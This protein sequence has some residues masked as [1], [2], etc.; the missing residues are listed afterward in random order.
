MSIQSRQRGLTLVELMIAM[1]IGILML[2]GVSLLFTQNKQS[3]RQN[4]EI[5]RIQENARFA[6]EELSRDISM[7]GFFA[8]VVDSGAVDVDAGVLGKAIDCG[9]GAAWLY[10][11]TAGLIDGA[12]R[13]SDQVASGAA[14]AADFS[15]ITAGA[16]FIPDSDVIGIRRTAGVPS[17]WE[18]D[19]ATGACVDLALPAAAP[20]VR[21]RPANGIFVR[22]NGTRAV[23]YHGADEA[24]ITAVTARPFEE[25]EY[26]PRVYYV[27]NVDVD[28]TDIPTLC[29]ARLDNTAGSPQPMA[30]E[31][32]VP[33]VESLQVELGVDTD[34][35]G[36]ANSYVSNPGPG[37]LTRAVSAR[38]YLLMRA[39]QLDVGYTDERQYTLGNLTVGPFNDRFHR[40]VYTATVAMRNLNNMR[41]LGF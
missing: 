17:F 21:L 29:R 30:E 25:W 10:D 38:V 41:Q 16:D 40:R 5:A 8:E 33:G 13:I 22:E 32:L 27:R 14:A 6:I 39:I 12:V 7:A 19:G 35:D 34:G 18:A 36:A 31:C 3:Y 9:D 26:T 37:D 2:L 28:G 15:C 4:E 11:F 23:L 1:A 24:G 20:C